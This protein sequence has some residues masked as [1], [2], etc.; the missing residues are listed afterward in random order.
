MLSR[1]EQGIWRLRAFRILISASMISIFGS[2][3][4][5]TAF[6]FIA[7]NELDAGPTEIAVLSLSS[8]VPTAVLGSVAGM[9]VDRLSRKTVLIS[10][11]LVSAAALITIPIA[12]WL[13][14]LSLALLFAVTFVTSLAKLTFRIADRSI[15]PSVVGREHVEEANA[16]LSGGSAIAEA[17]GFSVGGLLIQLLSGPVALA[18][19]AVSFVGSAV[20]LSRLPAVGTASDDAE[21]GDEPSLSHW[22]TELV[23]G[24]R[25]LR[26]SP[27]LSP[28]AITVFLMAVGMET[29]GTVY[30]LFVNQTLGF[31]AGALGFIFASGGIGSL[32]G[33]ALST[34]ATARF[35]A[36]TAIIGALVL[37]G[38]SWGSIT[39][40]SGVGVF[41][42]GL[43][44]GQQLSDAFWLYYESTSTSIRQLH[45]PEAML[46]RINGAFESV[47]F[48]GLLV[49]AGVGALIGETLGLRA[50]L[51]TGGGLVVLSGLAL[52]LSPV[53]NLKRLDGTE[54]TAPATGTIAM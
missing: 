20:L 47:E 10:S 40:A 18:F 45:A 32:I 11:D 3:I 6:P 22:R 35:G 37:L 33:A 5:A 44:L 9:W 48:T 19:D 4:T 51:I 2:L 23:D 27:I 41:A 15:L 30:F 29:T 26:R 16:T 38:L 42:V 21:D 53:R 17:G 25:F 14:E 8:V 50:A 24:V 31:S 12:Y 1:F 36:G 52:L 46:G 7:I 39:L 28:M 34:R 13:D 54:T 43:L 49:G